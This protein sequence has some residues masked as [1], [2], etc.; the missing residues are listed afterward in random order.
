[1]QG[2]G[3]V[4]GRFTGMVQHRRH[5]S[6][7]RKIFRQG[8]QAFF[9]P[10]RSHQVSGIVPTRSW[11]GHSVWFSVIK[12]KVDGACSKDTS[13]P[14]K[15]SHLLHSDPSAVLGNTWSG[16]QATLEEKGKS[17]EIRDLSEESS[18]GHRANAKAVLLLPGSALGALLQDATDISKASHP[19]SSSWTWRNQWCVGVLEMRQN[20]GPNCCKVAVALYGWAKSRAETVVQMHSQRAAGQEEKCHW[21]QALSTPVLPWRQSHPP[22]LWPS[23][24]RGIS[25][26]SDRKSRVCRLRSSE[27]QR[28][29]SGFSD[30]RSFPN[31]NP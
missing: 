9:K 6:V 27:C 8:L 16:H 12:A 29:R 25:P 26:I 2:I 7:K 4:G 17:E 28:G 19:P 10:H 22:R 30:L 24:P 23:H 20:H 14:E 18:A 1:M 15:S 5:I 3:G 21:E 11:I 31:C 13:I